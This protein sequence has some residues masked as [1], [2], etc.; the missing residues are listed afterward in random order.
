MKACTY[1]VVA[2]I[3]KDTRLV[4]ALLTQTL[5]TTQISPPTLRGDAPPDG[6]VVK[7]TVVEHGND[8]CNTMNAELIQEMVAMKNQGNHGL[9]TNDNT[10][11]IAPHGD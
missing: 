8:S 3:I 1:C 11:S 5:P 7:T 6:T 2:A 9:V 4:I 10:N